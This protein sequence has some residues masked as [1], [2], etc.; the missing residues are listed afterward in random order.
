[1]E[2]I[3]KIVKNVKDIAKPL[4][5]DITE[6]YNQPTRNN[7]AVPTIN[8]KF[9]QEQFERALEKLERIYDDQCKP[10]LEKLE[11]IK[12]KYQKATQELNRQYDLISKSEVISNQK[13]IEANYKRNWKLI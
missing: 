5:I 12:A 6:K 3:K 13:Q 11:K 10:H 7:F 4:I 2:N 9:N 8:G 1:M